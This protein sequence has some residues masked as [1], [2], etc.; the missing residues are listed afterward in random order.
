MSSEEEDNLIRLLDALIINMEAI[1]S[2]LAFLDPIVK[3]AKAEL[4][5]I[6]L[7]REIEQDIEVDQLKSEMLRP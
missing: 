6:K 1:G 7:T 4:D 3:S 5:R 2:Q